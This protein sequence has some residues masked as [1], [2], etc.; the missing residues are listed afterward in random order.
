MGPM[1]DFTEAKALEFWLRCT[2]VETIFVVCTFASG[3]ARAGAEQFRLACQITEMLQAVSKNRC[4]VLFGKERKKGKQYIEERNAMSC[5]LGMAPV[6]ICASDVA[7]CRRLCH[8]W[9]EW[10]GP[11]E[12]ADYRP[13]SMNLSIP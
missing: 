9:A 13:T 4:C 1:E 5:Y 12:A 11:Q 2:H 8:Y 6:T 3:D 10:L 7:P